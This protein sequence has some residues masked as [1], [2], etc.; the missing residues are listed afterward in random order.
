M[1]R[2]TGIRSRGL[3]SRKVPEGGR[4]AAAA[5]LVSQLSP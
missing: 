3:R 1:W 5:L 2:K 4:F